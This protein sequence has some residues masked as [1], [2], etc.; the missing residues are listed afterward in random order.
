MQG[1]CRFRAAF[2]MPEIQEEIMIDPTIAGGTDSAAYAQTAT[3]VVLMTT[4]FWAEFLYTLNIVAATIA[5]LCG[6]TVGLIGV[7]RIVRQ[8]RGQ[9]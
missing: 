7:W 3:G 6:A 2:F 1:H 5:S 4:P 8:K 9:S